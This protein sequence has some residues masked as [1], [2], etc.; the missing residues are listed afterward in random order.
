MP[1]INGIEIP[2]FGS[3]DEIHKVLT[4]ELNWIDKTVVINGFGF[5][6][7]EAGYQSNQSGICRTPDTWS[8]LHTGTAI[9]YNYECD[10][11]EMPP[12]YEIMTSG[13]VPHISKRCALCG[14]QLD[15]DG[16]KRGA[17]GPCYAE[18][19]GH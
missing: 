17:C 9:L 3:L 12:F 19:V 8:K 1:Q 7:K 2:C 14:M 16:I 11:E 18:E 13:K 5:T 6:V 4:K 10:D 15:Q